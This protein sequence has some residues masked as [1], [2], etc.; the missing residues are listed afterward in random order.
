MKR[1]MKTIRG[2]ATKPLVD[3]HVNIPE[4]VLDMLDGMKDE[5]N[6]SKSVIISE[7][8]KREHEALKA[9]DANG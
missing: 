7:L 1:K 4:D 2:L 6:V 9:E 3:I 8:I 5:M